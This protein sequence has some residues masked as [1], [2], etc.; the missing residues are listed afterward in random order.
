MNAVL[1]DD[2]DAGGDRPSGTARAAADARRALPSVDRLLRHERAAALVEAHGRASLL[3]VL[4]SLLQEE[5]E[6][7]TGAAPAEEDLLEACA[8]RLEREQA[9]SLRAVLNC[10]GTVLH[11][12]L[13]RAC[14]P[15][16]AARAALLAMTGAT[17]LEFDLASGG[18]GERDHHVEALLC[19]LTGAEAATVVNNNASA[20]MLALNT[21]ASRKEV[22]VSRGELV[23][24]GGAFRVPDVMSRAGCRLH[25]VGTTN[26][27]HLRDYEAALNPRT[28]AFMKVHTSNYVVEGFTAEVPQRELAQLAA[29]RGIPFLIDL[30]S[31]SLID[32]ARFGLPPEPTPRA[33]MEDG[34][35]AVT[36]SGDKLLGGPQCGIIVGRRALIGRMRAN[37][38]KRALRVDKMTLAALEATL[39]LYLDPERARREVPTLRW[40]T[41]PRPEIAALAQRLLPAFEAALGTAAKVEVVECMSQ[42]GSGAR[43]VDLLPSAGLA[44]RPRR[45]EASA[46]E[47]ARRFRALPLPVIGRVQKGLFLLDL[48]CIDDEQAL[49]GQLASLELA[50]EAP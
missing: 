45:N 6:R 27:T 4:R 48:R 42:I 16:A 1:N 24:I 28:A 30:G 14:L 31:G 44:I 34:A 15:E 2:D 46:A 26:R 20:V 25:E 41:R 11:T 47:W 29:S 7:G 35:D 21:V 5:R 18:R 17:N 39:R 22:V 19:R 37:P 49:V 33:A 38:L 40:L 36:F 10:S 8:R 43:P 13:G 9:P 12:N 3:E 32:L 23:E 50:R